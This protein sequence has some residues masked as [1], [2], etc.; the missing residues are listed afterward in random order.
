MYEFAHSSFLIS[1]R[2]TMVIKGFEWQLANDI[3]LFGS[4]YLLDL[5]TTQRVTEAFHFSRVPTEKDFMQRQV[6]FE[7]T[8]ANTNVVLVIRLEKQLEGDLGT[9]LEYT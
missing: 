3:P 9:W 5:T 7:V 2:F 1:R 4:A 8:N 6:H